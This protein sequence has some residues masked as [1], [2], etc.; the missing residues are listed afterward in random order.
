MQKTDRQW[1]NLPLFCP[2]TYG[3]TCSNTYAI[4]PV[5][6]CQVAYSYANPVLISFGAS[7]LAVSA[8]AADYN[9]GTPQT[10]LV[11]YNYSGIGW[12]FGGQASK[13]YSSQAVM[14]HE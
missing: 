12:F 2:V 13:S 9:T 3:N 5:D 1:L 6:P 11:R 7:S 14:L 10:L 8:I 4:S